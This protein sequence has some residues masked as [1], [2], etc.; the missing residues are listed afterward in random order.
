M[1]GIGRGEIPDSEFSY[2]LKFPAKSGSGDTLRFAVSS[3]VPYRHGNVFHA[4]V[5]IKIREHYDRSLEFFGKLKAFDNI[6]IALR[7]GGWGDYD[8]PGVAGTAVYSRVRKS[9][10]SVLVGSPVEGPPR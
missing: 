6:F 4:V 3:A 2:R 9:D 5:Q 1:L 10:C 7:H 8:P